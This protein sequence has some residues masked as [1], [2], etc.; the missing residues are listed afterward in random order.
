[1][2]VVIVCH[3]EFGFVSANKEL[4]YDKSFTSGVKEGVLNL[5]KL[6]KKYNAKISFAVCPEVLPYFPKQ[7]NHEIGLHVHPGWK[8]VI[9]NKSRWISGDRYLKENCK[10]TINSNSLKDFPYAEQLEMIEK[11][12]KYLFLEFQKEPKFFV[13]GRWSFNNDTAR[14]VSAAGFKSVYSILPRKKDYQEKDNLPILF[15]PVSMTIF[16]GPASPE[17]VIQYGFKWLKA[18]FF[19]HLNQGAP[20][21]HFY[22]HSPSMT[23]PYYIST[24]DDFLA[25][26]SKQ[27][28]INFKFASE[29]IEHPK[30]K[31]RPNIFPYI[32]GINKNLVKT[33]WRK[34][35]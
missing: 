21:F 13:P 12:K 9:S 2:D 11:G 23:D 34:L 20:L 17:G 29:V 16:G 3:T 35:N 28:N 8:E 22:L 14:A 26:I 27:K 24:L 10:Q 5:S 33:L 25:L 18:C 7:I 15:V 30:N 1:M 31:L 32:L 4:V 6:A 19:D